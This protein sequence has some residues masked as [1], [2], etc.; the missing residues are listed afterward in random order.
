MARDEP[1]QQE[2]GGECAEVENW[3]KSDDAG[4]VGSSRLQGL[5]GSREFQGLLQSVMLSQP[6]QPLQLSLRL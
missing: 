4:M 1:L 2:S 3:R 5:Q 6:L